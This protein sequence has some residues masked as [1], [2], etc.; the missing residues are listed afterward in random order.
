MF[1]NVFHDYMIGR[2]IYSITIQSEE[3]PS[4]VE[5]NKTDAHE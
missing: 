4:N 5:D 2:V 1:L 3:A